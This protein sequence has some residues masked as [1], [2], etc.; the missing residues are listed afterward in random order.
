MIWDSFFD[1]STENIGSHYSIWKSATN[2]EE[3][4]SEEDPEEIIHQGYLNKTEANNLSMKE[5]YFVLTKDRLYYKKVTHLHA[6]TKRTGL[7]R[8]HG[9]KVHANNQLQCGR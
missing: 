3:L 7:Q 1:D 8:L 5:R 2:E 4:E 6:E 9:G